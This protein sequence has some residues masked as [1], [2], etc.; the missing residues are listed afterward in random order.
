MIRTWIH[1]EICT[2][3]DEGLYPFGLHYSTKGE[4]EAG[5][6]VYRP[7]HPSAFI[8]TV[9]KTRSGV[10]PQGGL[11]QRSFQAVQ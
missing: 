4:A 6:K 11:P 1:Y 8:I 3:D 5:L 7:A 10:R 2:E 9:V